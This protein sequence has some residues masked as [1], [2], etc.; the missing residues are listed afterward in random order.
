M[1]TSEAQW[2]TASS[3]SWYIMIMIINHILGTVRIV[4]CEEA[5]GVTLRWDANGSQDLQNR[6][7]WGSRGSSTLRLFKF[8][9]KPCIGFVTAWV[10][11]KVQ[12]PLTNQAWFLKNNTCSTCVKGL[13]AESPQDLKISWAD[14]SWQWFVVEKS[15]WNS[16]TLFCFG[17]PS[18]STPGRDVAIHS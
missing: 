14:N 9:A 3:W 18:T 12:I 2:T 8:A 13:S 10:W 1:Q 4:L 6:V 15:S 11:S 5:H 17:N 7:L 16:H